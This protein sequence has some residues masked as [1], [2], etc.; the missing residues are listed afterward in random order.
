MK[1]DGHPRK[2]GKLLRFPTFDASENTPGLLASKRAEGGSLR[3]AWI[4]TFVRMTLVG[5]DVLGGASR[6]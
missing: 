4:L 3:L 6:G 5:G 1:W 2:P